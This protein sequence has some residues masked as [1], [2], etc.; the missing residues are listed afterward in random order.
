MNNNLYMST[1]LKAFDILDCFESD[2]QEIGI[3]DIAA[4]VGLPVSSVH[5]IIQSLEFEGLLSQNQESKKYALG[6]KMLS[7]S[8]KCGQYQRFQQIAA[9]YADELCRITQENVNVATC[10]G[11]QIT[12]I[13]TAETHFIL[14]PN[15]PVHTPFPIHCTGVGRVFLSHMPLAAQK[16]VYE[17]NAQAIGMTQDEFLDLLQKAKQDGYALDDQAF[18]A[19]LRCVAA[20][21]YCSGD[22]LL[23]AMSVSA[24]LARMDDTVYENARRLVLEYADRISQEIQAE[25]IRRRDKI[26]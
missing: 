9:K 2:R 20:P 11:D 15:F 25:E 7:Y 23:F 19:G 12:N 1:L 26:L 5:R 18:N 4:K 8:Q 14:R 3:S 24:P 17:A 6:S 21:I 10:S 16:W 13:Y 22:K